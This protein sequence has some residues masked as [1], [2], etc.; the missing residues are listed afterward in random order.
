MLWR[1]LLGVILMTGLLFP[2]HLAAQQKAAAERPLVYRVRLGEPWITPTTTAFVENAI[3]KAQNE[4]AE[5]LVL[6][7]NVS[8]GLLD[9]TREVVQA[10]VDSPIPVVVYVEP[11]GAKVL[12]AGYEIALASHVFALAPGTSVGEAL[13]ANIEALPAFADTPAEVVEESMINTVEWARVLEK[14]HQRN[15]DQA[16]QSIREHLLMSADKAVQS[17]VA[18]LLANDF[19]DLLLKIHGRE[20]RLSNGIQELNTK[21][22]MVRKLEMNPL[23]QSLAV[24]ENPNVPFA[25]MLLG[26]YGMLFG[27]ARGRWGWAGYLS[28]AVF[29]A[30]L[31]GLGLL[32][33]QYGAV[34]LVVAGVTFYIIAVFVPVFGV[35][36]L[37]ATACLVIGGL[38]LFEPAAGFMRVTPWLVWVGSAL[39][40]LMA[41]YAGGR[42]GQR[43]NYRRG[44]WLRQSRAENNSPETL[45]QGRH[46]MAVQMREE[47]AG[48]ILAVRLS[49]KLTKQDYE[50]FLPEVARLIG[51]HGKIRILVQMHDFH[52]WTVGALGRTSSSI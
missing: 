47:A 43:S 36:G 42:F 18:D 16:A 45:D 3:Q 46:P 27:L 28:L 26:L 30:G 2:R 5:C 31:I 51:Q 15:G 10:F 9:S 40:M 50:H 34:L 14:H 32:P 7:L 49:G 35:F 13:P 8:C 22:A 19:D 23:Q 38:G 21:G 6:C 25:A 39:A 12:S 11:S 33:S 17:G 20:V 48:K 37:L 29:S 4:R 1:L 52:G 44:G 24:G 41:V